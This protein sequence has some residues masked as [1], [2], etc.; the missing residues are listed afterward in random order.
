MNREFCE[1]QV[2]GGIKSYWV[3]CLSSWIWTGMKSQRCK[4]HYTNMS[5]FSRP[6]FPGVKTAA[7][8]KKKARN[9]KVTQT[10]LSSGHGLRKHYHE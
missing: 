5:P 7:R 3:R 1:V 6:V 10:A 2:C 8:Q 9:T 4:L